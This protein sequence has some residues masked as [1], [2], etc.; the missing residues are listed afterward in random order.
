MASPYTVF[1]ETEIPMSNARKQLIAAAIAAGD[2]DYAAMIAARKCIRMHDI[3]PR[4]AY[5]GI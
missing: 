5:Y 4:L 3:L 1:I 2:H